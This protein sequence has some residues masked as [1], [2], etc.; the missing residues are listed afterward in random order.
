M[1]PYYF[2]IDQART[3]RAAAIIGFE[4]VMRSGWPPP[5]RRRPGGFVRTALTLCAVG[6]SVSASVSS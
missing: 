1:R 4:R 6:A 2:D 5:R 3:R